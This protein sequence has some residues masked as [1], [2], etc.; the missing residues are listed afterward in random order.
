MCAAVIAIPHE[1]IEEIH[2]AVGHPGIK[3]TLYFV[4]RVDPAVTRRQVQAVV[5]N[6]RA[7]QSIDPAPVKWRKGSLEVERVWQKVGMDVTHCGSQRYLTLIDCGPSRFSV[8]RQLKLQ[9]SDSIIKQLE[10]VFYE[11]GAPEELL[12]DNDTAFRSKLFAD[13]VKRWDVRLRFRCAH[14]PSGNGIVERCHRTIKVIAARK[15][16]SVAKA[17]YLYNL[18]P[19]DDHESSSAPANMVYQYPVRVRGVDPCEESKLEADGLYQPGYEVWVRPPNARCD[20]QHTRGRVNKTLSHQAV[21]VDGV[22]RHVRDLH[23]CTPQ[24]PQEDDVTT[25]SEDDALLIQLPGQIDEEEEN[26]DAA[27]GDELDQELPRRSSRI[28]RHKVCTVCE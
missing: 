18:R 7:C 15:G 26:E 24:T 13:F 11:R 25:D 12:T 8:W 10:A 19:N 6:C 23:H 4:R 5:A 9:T 16:C 1:K 14:V 3:R 17:V 20:E 27:A 21:E 22:P 2:H 28:R